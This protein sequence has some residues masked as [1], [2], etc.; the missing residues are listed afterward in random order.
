MRVA[1]LGAG[2][3]GG[4]FGGRLSQAGEDVVFIARGEHLNAM[5]THGLRV[6]SIN[7]DFLIQSVQATDDPSKI[8]K[9]DIVLVGV[10]AWQV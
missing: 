2:S 7:G 3:V 9:V 8:G 4:Y 5:L 10:K 1:I 6:D